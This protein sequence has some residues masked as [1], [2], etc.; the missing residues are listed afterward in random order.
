MSISLNTS[1]SPEAIEKAA[2]KAMTSTFAAFEKQ[3]DKLHTGRAH[4]A[5]LENIHVAQSH[6]GSTRLSYIANIT[7]IDARTLKIIPFDIA[8]ISAIAKS[9]QQS[10]LSLNPDVR[11]TEILILLPPLSDQRRKD[12]IRLM[13]KMTEE[14]FEEIR[15]HRRNANNQCK[16]LLKEKV[17]SE[18]E[19]RRA[20]KKIQQITDEYIAHIKKLA[21]A[22]EQQILLV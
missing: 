3:L 11:K 14:M 18:D 6:G 10:E 8:Q 1:S 17:I 22:K 4:P 16:G 12:I 7:V 20:H 2:M 19:E 5:L 9:I 13:H 21:S 15:N